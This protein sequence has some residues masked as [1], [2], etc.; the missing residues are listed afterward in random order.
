MDKADKNIINNWAKDFADGKFNNPYKN[1]DGNY[2][3]SLSEEFEIYKKTWKTVEQMQKIEQFDT[4]KAWDKL[5]GKITESNDTNYQLEEKHFKLNKI[6][7]IAASIIVLIG[8]AGFFMFKAHYSQTVSVNNTLAAKLVTL[9]DGSEV[10]LNANSEI[11]YPK[12]FKKNRR[13]VILTGEAFFNVTK[14]KNRPFVVQADKTFIRV[15]GTSFNV[16]AKKRDI[17]VIVKTGKVEVY[18]KQNSNN[19]VV[20][21]PGDRAVLL[22]DNKIQKQANNNNNYLSWLSK[23]L[24][25]KELPLSIV[26]NDLINTYHCN[27]E[28][29]DSATANL[30][31][32]STFDNDSINDILE[33][34]S[35]AFNLH[36]E[37]T[38][39]KYILV[40]NY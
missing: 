29:A 6:F 4:D 40:S 15:L 26:I 38:G 31:I 19:H 23:K 14:N 33:S 17:E 24:V 5:F 28:L 20:L 39:K 22:P 18:N 37:K 11:R 35:L 13:N 21:L 36:I 16:N 2:S 1:V 9:P 32:T 3:V 12:N 7:S 30:K 10:Y 34:I 27:I 8:I 25:F